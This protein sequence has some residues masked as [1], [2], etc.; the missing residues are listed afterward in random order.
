ME[1]YTV[2]IPAR[3]SIDTLK[4]TLQTCLT[5]TYPNFEILI[6]DNC[7]DD[8]TAQYIKNLNDKR[9]RY[10]RS[11]RSLSMTENFEF[12]LSHAR[13]GFIMCIGADDGLM[14]DAI[15]YVNEIVTKYGVQAIACQY[16]YYLWSNA[17]VPE[18]GRLLLNALNE[19][20]SNVEIRNS[21][22]WI[23]KTLAF[24]SAL[25]VCDLPSLYYGFVHR[26]IID[27][28]VKDGIYFRSITPDAFSAFATAISTD[29]YAFSFKPFCISGISGKSNGLSQT[30]G[31]D[32]SKAFVTET[33]HSI[34][35]DFVFCPAM[36][37][38]LSEAF[39][40]LA[41]A[42]PDKCKG[43]SI[44]F[45]K[46]LKIAIIKSNKQ[47]FNAVIDASMR[48]A[49]IHHLNFKNIRRNRFYK[50]KKFAR[51]SIKMFEMFLTNGRKYLGM[52]NSSDFQITNIYEASIAL[53]ILEAANRG[54]RL[55]TVRSKFLSRL[56]KRI[57]F[58]SDKDT[59]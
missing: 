32:I 22:E 48:M 11:E 42:F 29:T 2:V 41:E 3:N 40:Q 9:L 20:K 12:A 47:T 30:I 10:I 35:K 25:Y 13:G 43:Y 23:K 27:K 6:S 56:K 50:I 31:S 54:R 18:R 57:F 49:E 26:S 17:P 52:K 39:Y 5:Q 24:K 21:S 14:P 33:A 37:V 55:E 58:L 53:S 45:S 36:E 44:D 34:H 7:S 1:K 46:M 51:R 38:I 4:Y 8:G 28:S 59:L 16:A 15:N 19:Y